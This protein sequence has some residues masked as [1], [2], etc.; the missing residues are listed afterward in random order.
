MKPVISRCCFACG[1]DNP[2]GLKL[3]IEGDGKRVTTRFRP[4][5]EHEGWEGMLHGGIIATLLDELVA[6]IC[7]K[8]GIDALTAKLEI[9]YRKPARIGEE[10]LAYAELVE[11]RGRIVKAKARVVGTKEETVAEADALLL[12][13]A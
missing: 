13:G 4:R 10:L 1:P 3:D 9:R 5:R 11:Y 2:I 8:N 6:W 12:R 7:K